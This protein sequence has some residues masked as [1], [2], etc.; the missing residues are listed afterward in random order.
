M[1]HIITNLLSEKRGA[2]YTNSEFQFFAFYDNTLYIRDSYTIKSY[3]L[4][5]K[6]PKLIVDLSR[7]MDDVKSYKNFMIL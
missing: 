2:A 4:T 1:S 5:D 3:S 6:E 7:Y